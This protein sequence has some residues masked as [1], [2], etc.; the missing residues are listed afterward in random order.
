M[1]TTFDNPDQI[2]P[3][4]SAAIIALNLKRIDKGNTFGTVSLRFRYWEGL[5]IHGVLWGRTSNGASEW[6]LPPCQAWRAANGTTT[7]TTLI[8]WGDREAQ[9]RFERAALL[10]IHKLVAE[11]AA[12]AKAGG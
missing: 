5:Q 7:R 12:K 1:P 9:K 8:E 3:D 2:P 6:V 11:E 10:A 4:T